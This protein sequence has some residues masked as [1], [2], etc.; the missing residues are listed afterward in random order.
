MNRNS[1]KRG[2]MN[3]PEAASERKMTIHLPETSST[4]IEMGV[5]FHTYIVYYIAYIFLLKFMLPLHKW[6]LNLNNNTHTS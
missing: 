1:D 5:S 4:N 6:R 3:L 2:S